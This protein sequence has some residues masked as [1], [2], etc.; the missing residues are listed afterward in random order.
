MNSMNVIVTVS[1]FRVLSTLVSNSCNDVILLR[2]IGTSRKA[3]F[4]R[5]RYA[6]SALPH[7][8]TYTLRADC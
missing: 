7:V 8:E 1:F 3:R 4:H 2:V 5:G 6:R